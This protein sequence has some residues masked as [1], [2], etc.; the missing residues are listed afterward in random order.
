MIIGFRSPDRIFDAIRAWRSPACRPW[1]LIFKFAG[2]SKSGG[3]RF[4]R[5]DFLFLILFPLFLR[6]RHVGDYP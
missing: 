1:V 5:A 2:R 6:F 4:G 3:P